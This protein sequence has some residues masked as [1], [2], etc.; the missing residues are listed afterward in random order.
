MIGWSQRLAPG[1]DDR[2]LAVFGGHGHAGFDS[3]ALHPG[4]LRPGVHPHEEVV[5]A[6]KQQEPV[7]SYTL[8]TREDSSLTIEALPKQFKSGNSG[9]F[10]QSIWTI[11]GKQYKVQVQIVL[12]A[13]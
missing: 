5:M 10:G 8:T 9:W 3:R 13:E 7:V 12:P 1:L 6:K 2:G 4:Q 11:G